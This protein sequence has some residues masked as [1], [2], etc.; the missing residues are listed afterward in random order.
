V[1]A[2]VAILGFV[3]G[4]V[5]DLA[6]Q[7]L[8]WRSAAVAAAVLLVVAGHVDRRIER[9]R[10]HLTLRAHGFASHQEYIRSDLWRDRRRRWLVECGRRPC[11]VCGKPWRDTGVY[12]AHHLDYAHAG[13]GK[14]R[15]RDLTP[16]CS[17]CHTLIHT[18]D[19]HLRALGFSLRRTT[20]LVAVVLRPARR[21]LPEVPDVPAP[22]SRRRP[23]RRPRARITARPVRARPR[24]GARRRGAAP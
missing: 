5:A 16:V 21:L 22:P 9:A 19:R 4:G 18:A 17:R 10:F 15:D 1:D 14:E 11:R 20:S 24:T 23:A 13:A 6:R 7:D 8:T 2:V 3:L 12:H